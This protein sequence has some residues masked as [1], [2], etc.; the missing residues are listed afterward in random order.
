[1]KK[2]LKKVLFK[3]NTDRYSDNSKIKRLINKL[4]SFC[5]GIILAIQNYVVWGPKKI[6][7][8]K[9]L[10]KNKDRKLYILSIMKN[11]DKYL[12]EWLYYHRSIGV[13]GFIIYDN[14]SNDNSQ[15]IIEKHSKC[16]DID[17]TYFTGK[18]RQTA[19]YQDA[20]ERYRKKNVW[21]LT[22]DI[23]EFLR[24]VNKLDIKKWL[25]SFSPNVSQILIP[26]T[27]YGSAGHEKRQVG[28]VINNYPYHSNINFITEYKSIV[29]PESVRL[30]FMGGHFYKSIGRIVNE[31]GKKLWYYPYVL[32]IGSRP[33]S[34][35]FMTI[36]H[37]YCKS[38]QDFND[39]IG[40]G[41]AFNYE[42][43]LRDFTEFEI[44]DRNEVMDH[45]TQ[46]YLQKIFLLR[47]LDE[48]KNNEK[49]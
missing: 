4:L 2:K 13:D 19:A 25:L 11:E 3:K 21:I 39:K 24:P 32:L 1:M 8:A 41:D 33:S 15:S 9:K 37:Y 48:S 40:R 26:W 18:S 38:I 28:L 16:V 47:Q 12:D 23:D 29:K 17:Y 5:M 31:S 35:N 43:N 42:N 22:I 14:E 44:Q 30:S 34:R 46:F 6:H 49:V 36:N 45:E 27:I 10:G 7:Q 20:I